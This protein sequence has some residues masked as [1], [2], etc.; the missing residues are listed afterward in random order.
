MVVG[1]HLLET[2]LSLCQNSSYCI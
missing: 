1:T 2:L